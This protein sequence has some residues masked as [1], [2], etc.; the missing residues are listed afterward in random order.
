MN[1]DIKALTKNQTVILK[2]GE[3]AIINGVKGRWINVTLAGADKPKNIGLKDVAGIVEVEQTPSTGR[4]N[5]IVPA[6]YL[7]SYAKVTLEDGTITRDNGDDVAI[8]L[9][10]KELDEVVRIVAHKIGVTQAVLRERFGHL[11]PGQQRMCL[12]NVLRKALRDADK[13]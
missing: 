10:G 6:H 3:T 8:L 11:N 4:R 12:G 1:I 13:E 9:R 5:G 2:G 7:D